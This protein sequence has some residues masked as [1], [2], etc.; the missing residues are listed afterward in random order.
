MIE[1]FDGFLNCLNQKLPLSAKNL[2]LRGARLKNTEW[3][4]GIVVYTSEDTKI[5]KNSE[6]GK[7]KQSKMENQMNNMILIVL[8][9]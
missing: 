8:V 1:S 5:M 4:I 6:K 7:H 3:A 2:L 9:F